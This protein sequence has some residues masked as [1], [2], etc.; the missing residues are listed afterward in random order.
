[1]TKIASTKFK[2]KKNIPITFFIHLYFALKESFQWNLHLN[3]KSAEC[4]N[5]IS[6][7]HISQ[8]IFLFEKTLKFKQE[9]AITKNI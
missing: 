8:F 1:M 3:K 6:L 4:A 7:V 9:K 5:F 2:K